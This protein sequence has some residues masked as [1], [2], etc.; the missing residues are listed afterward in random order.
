[1]G[2]ILQETAT[3]LLHQPNVL[4]CNKCNQNWLMFF[5]ISFKYVSHVVAND[6]DWDILIVCRFVF[7][8]LNFLSLWLNCA[9]PVCLSTTDWWLKVDFSQFWRLESSRSSCWQSQRPMTICFLAHRC[10]SSCCVL[11][12]QQRWGISLGSPL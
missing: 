10:P 8:I 2:T 3:L 9:T 5:G 4:F 12:Q 6:R 11:R 1:M 7:S